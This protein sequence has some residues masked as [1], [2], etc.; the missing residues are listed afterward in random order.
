[1]NIPTISRNIIRIGLPKI[2]AGEQAVFQSFVI[3]CITPIFRAD[4]LRPCFFSLKEEEIISRVK[5]GGLETGLIPS[6]ILAQY[7]QSNNGIVQAGIFEN[8]FRG[9]KIHFTYIVKK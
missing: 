7:L 5:H 4:G 9:K 6:V 2:M 8:E 1:M 3:G